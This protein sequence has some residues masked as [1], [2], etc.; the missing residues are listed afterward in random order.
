MNL[1][2]KFT[3]TKGWGITLT[4]NGIKDIIKVIKSLKIKEF[5]QK[6]I[7]KKLLVKMGEF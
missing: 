6:E 2:R 1:I 5:Y 3:S 7:L 4:V